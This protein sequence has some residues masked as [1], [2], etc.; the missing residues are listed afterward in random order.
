[1][2]APAIA[3]P[4]REHPAKFS[5]AVLDAIEAIVLDEADRLNRVVRVLDPFAGVGR[6][7]RLPADTIGVELEPEWAR[8][9]DERNVVG[10][11]LHLPLADDSIDVLATSPCYGNRLAD[12]HDA[13]D[14]CKPCGG[15]GTI[16]R[17]ATPAE[18]DAGCELGIA[19]DRC[20][21]CKGEGLSR[22]NTYRH[23]LGRP[24]SIGSSAGLQW[25]K[26]YREF[27]GAAWREA[28]RVLRKP[29]ARGPKQ[30]LEPG[31][32]AIVNVS[33]F[34]Q[35][36][37]K[38]GPQLERPV[39]EWHLNAWISLGATLVDARRVD[40]QRN[41]HG[42]NRDARIVGEMILVFRPGMAAW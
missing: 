35:T 19:F 37:E 28:I 15:E 11:A 8:Q 21:S 10:D 2:T 13:R 39:V 25:G 16:E 32:L 41:G 22:R 31:G 4:V 26:A 1:M 6:I 5:P 33:N 23:R 40:T 38:G 12:Q 34:L 42:A 17:L 30:P 29:V 24:L 20:K 18:V 3:A 9:A 14:L 36:A 27:H 7:H